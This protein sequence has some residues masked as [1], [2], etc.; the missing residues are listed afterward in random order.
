MG[1]KIKKLVCALLTSA[2]IVSSVGVISFADADKDEA[3]ADQD[4]VTTTVTPEA[5]EAPTDKPETTPEATATPVAT[6]APAETQEPEESSTYDKDNYYKKSLA[7]CSALGIISGYEDGSVKPDSN[8]TRAE[9]ASIVL[10]MLAI[11]T[12]TPY[13]NSFTDVDSSHWAA[14]QIQT[15]MQQKIISGMGDGTFA[16][17]GD[18]TYAQVLVMLVNALNYTYEAEM[19]GGWNGNGYLAQAD[20]LGLTKS[21]TGVSEVPSTRGEV[22]KMVYNSLLADYKDIKSYVNGAPTYAAEETLAEAKFEVIEGKGTLMATSKTTLTDTKMQENQIQIKDSKEVKD[23]D[24]IKTYDCTLTGLEEYLAQKIT[25]YYRE[26]SGRTPEVLAVANDTTKSDTFVIEDIKD[27]ES[28][29]GFESN[30]GSIKLSGVGRA[31]DCT[32][33]S[34]IYNGKLITNKIYEDLKAKAASSI[35]DWKFGEDINDLFQPEIGK[36]K[37]VDSDRDGVFDVVFLD[38]YVTMVISSASSDKLNGIVADTTSGEVGNTMSVGYNF[39]DSEDRTITVKKGESEARIR[40][41]KKDDVASIKISLDN[42]VADIVVTGEVITGAASNVSKKVGESKATVNGT[43]Y[44]VADVAAGDLKAGVQATFA[45]DQFGRIANVISASGGQLETGEKYGWIMNAYESENGEDYVIKMMTTDGKEAEFTTGAK[46][47]DCWTQDDGHQ[48]LSSNELKTKLTKMMNDQTLV[49]GPDTF[50]K[51]TLAT[52]KDGDKVVPTEATQVRLVKYKANNSGN[53]TRLYFAI[54]EKSNKDADG[55]LKINPQNLGGISMTAGLVSGYKIED[56]G[57]EISVPKTVADMKTSGNYKV[58]TVTASTYAVRENGSS[59]TFV[60]G[61]CGDSNTPTVIINY[62]ASSDAEANLNDID[63]V[64]NNPTMVITSIDSDIDENDELVYLINGYAGSEEVSVT[65]T[66]NTVLGKL[67][68]AGN[69]I[70]QNS[71]R[72]YMTTQLWSAQKSKDDLTEYLGEGDVILYDGG[73]RIIRVL[74][75]DEVYQQIHNGV[76]IADSLGIGGFDSFNT[77]NMMVYAPLLSCDITSDVVIE[78]D[79]ERLNTLKFDVSKL[80]ATIDITVK[81]DDYSVKVDKDGSEAYDLEVYDPTTKKGDVVY[82]RLA[83]K[84]ELQEIVIYRF[85]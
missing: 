8:V 65:T 50:L 27:I 79:S 34:I 68:N 47:I 78:L 84:G 74:D 36:I 61:E 83:N 80:M 71:P 17:D 35:R 51:V 41:L 46:S 39:D 1:N 40:N 3:T 12:H 9:M 31:K 55:A 23:E 82:A 2:M 57:I 38:S 25:F 44:D 11:T 70:I 21:V 7:L 18:V 67:K 52:K 30:K 59:R 63:T 10:R 64:A 81:D 76:T 54:D 49:T 29:T 45:L 75:A 48:T 62:T 32:K 19:Q 26:N 6:E 60:V 66:G 73:E 42:T 72:A 53:L 14:D 33:A 24:Q 22:I 85:K 56:G 28:V 4:T 15:A 69:V 58:G 37:L 16:P 20:I 77:R 13:Q 5:T 43:K